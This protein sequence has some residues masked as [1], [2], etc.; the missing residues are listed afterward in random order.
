MAQACGYVNV[1]VISIKSTI[2]YIYR[3]CHSI[4][5]GYIANW[6]V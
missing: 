1:D 4:Q 6:R 2:R 3:S 5:I